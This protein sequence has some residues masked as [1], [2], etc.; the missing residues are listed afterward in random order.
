MKSTR[1]TGIWVCFLGVT[2]LSIAVSHALWW[3]NWYYPILSVLA[4]I[5]VIVGIGILRRYNFKK[6]VIAIIGVCLVGGQLW[7]IKI[8]LLMLSFR[9]NGI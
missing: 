7:L 3:S 1:L 5:N 2:V 4:T 8:S 6:S 9:I